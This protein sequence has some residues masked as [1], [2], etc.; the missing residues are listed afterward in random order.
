MRQ[1]DVRRYCLPCSESTGR[2]VER[3]CPALERR[4]KASKERASGRTKAAREREVR[5][6]FFLADGTDV[7]RIERR[8]KALRCW[9]REGP[10]VVVAVRNTEPLEVKGR[11]GV[12]WQ[13]IAA[14]YLWDVLTR[15]LRAMQ[16]RG[17]V[18][19]RVTGLA[20]V[21]SAELFEVEPREILAV[22]N[23]VGQLRGGSQGRVRD[24]AVACAKA[25]GHVPKWLRK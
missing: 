6:R 5:R 11:E 15:A 3:V 25:A 10:G 4:R 1:D 20:M 7:R 23:V 21:A 19:D 8:V 18:D 12:A 9:K 22:K 16:S 2:L 17:R 14:T 13:E 24:A